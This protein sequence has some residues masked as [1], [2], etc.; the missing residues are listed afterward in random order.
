MIYV[1]I[2]IEA[3]FVLKCI[4]PCSS[5]HLRALKPYAF[6]SRLIPTRSTAAKL[7]GGRYSGPGFHFKYHKICY[8][9]ILKKNK[10]GA[11]YSIKKHTTRRTV[12]DTGMLLA[13]A[14]SKHTFS[15]ILC[16]LRAGSVNERKYIHTTT[17]FVILYF[18]HLSLGLS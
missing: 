4:C 6:N 14:Q 13:A 3:N 11:G 10:S 15:L 2:S 16:Y 9:M 12:A 8:F 18:T 1:Y 5:R 17:Y 7:P